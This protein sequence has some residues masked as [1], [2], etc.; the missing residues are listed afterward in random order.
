MLEENIIS[1]SGLRSKRTMLSTFVFLAIAYNGNVF[2]NQLPGTGIGDVLIGIEARSMD[3]GSKLESTTPKEI[4]GDLKGTK[5]ADKEIPSGERIAVKS[6]TFVGNEMIDSEILK[7]RI[8]EYENKDLTLAEIKDAAREITKVY[9]E[10]GYFVARAYIPQQESVDGVIKIGILEGVIGNVKL[11][12]KS[13]LLDDVIVAY[14]KGVKNE[15]IVLSIKFERR[16]ILL[17]ELSGVKEVKINASAGQKVGESDIEIL[18][19][20]E[21]KYSGQV[22]IDNYGSKYAGKHRVSAIFD[23]NNVSGIGD[24]FTF[25]GL[26]SENANSK[27]FSADYVMPLG[28]E[29]WK[30]GG[31]IYNTDYDLSR[32]GD[33]ISYGESTG[34][35]A[36]ASYPFVKTQ[37]WTSEVVFGGYSQIMTDSFGIKG[38]KDKSKKQNNSLNFSL[39]NSLST[40]FFGNSGRLYNS[41]TLSG[42]NLS[43]KNGVAKD[44]DRFAKTSGDWSKIE[45]FTVHRQ[46]IIDGLSLQTSLKIQENLGRNLDGTEKVSLTGNSGVRSYLSSELNADSG[47]VASAD[48]IY[49]IYNDGNYSQDVSLFVDRAEGRKQ[50]NP[51]DNGLPNY[52]ALNAVG[53]GYRFEVNDKFDFDA[54]FARGFG[55]DSSPQVQR[56]FSKSKNKLSFKATLKF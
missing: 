37:E 39:N 15:R 45:I 3:R 5:I 19:V 28:Y 43:N 25:A 29:G 22:S 16:A 53:V 7:L 47:Y 44:Q 41:V 48:L 6:F 4:F 13:D 27:S 14:T 18:V 55:G 10:S 30:L 11:D 49:N 9:R 8:Q 20:P 34:L 38:F 51:I 31:S 32:I 42:G 52:R 40:V 50:R 23:I 2:A 56:E 33:L 35:R 46:R 36:W 1:G 21:E 54:T 17:N 26:L 12:N 24:Q